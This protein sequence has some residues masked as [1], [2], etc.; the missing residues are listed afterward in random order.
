[1]AANV[2]ISGLRRREPLILEH[3][4]ENL[5]REP[6]EYIFADHYKLRQVIATMDRFLTEGLFVS[7]LAEDD[8]SDL[9]VIRE[10]LIN[11][12]PAH[13][14][15]EEEDLFPYLEQRCQGDGDTKQILDTLRQEHVEDF[16]LLPS[17]TAGLGEL[18][19]GEA[20]SG[21]EIFEPSAAR[22]VETQRRHVIWEN[23]IVLPLARRHL[24]V[25]DM[26]VM[27]RK[28]AARRNIEFPA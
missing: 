22:F 28:M 5:L 27:G 13:I 19:A 25:D 20:V 4:P 21:R 15:D 8:A 11:E 12:L 23:N 24:T 14:A 26:T 7:P 16:A 3:I 18:L 17:V 2:K 9:S 1:M 6:V 10:Y